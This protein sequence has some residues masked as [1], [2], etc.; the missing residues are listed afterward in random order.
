MGEVTKEVEEAIAT[1]KLDKSIIS[2][3][4]AQYNGILY[5]ELL[6]FF[7]NGEDRRWWW[8]AF[9]SSF[10][11]KMFDYP[12]DHFSEI[13]PDLTRKVW[14]MIEDVQDDFYPIYDV[15]P[16]YI[17]DILNECFGFEYYIIDKDYKWLLCENHHDSLFGVGDILKEHNLSLLV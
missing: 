11:F 5:Y 3:I 14:L 2:K 1:L 7:V 12:P 9:K 8:E 10:E 15:D 16:N 4:D 6:A 13:I 17:R